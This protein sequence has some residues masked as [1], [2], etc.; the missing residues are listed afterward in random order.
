MQVWHHNSTV[1]QELGETLQEPS[2]ALP[3]V[4]S[5]R[6]SSPPKE[7]VFVPWPGTGGNIWSWVKSAT[8]QGAV[9]SQ[10]SVLPCPVLQLHFCVQLHIYFS[11]TATLMLPFVQK[12]V[13]IDIGCPLLTLWREKG[14]PRYKRSFQDSKVI[15]L[16]TFGHSS[17]INR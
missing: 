2:G 17:A 5:Q 7:T 15:T 1:W 9:V 10:L 8:I 13:W 11:T 3:H 4:P 14:H 6:Q 12:P 16:Y